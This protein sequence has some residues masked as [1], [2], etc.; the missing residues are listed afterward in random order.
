[1]S[2]TR[3]WGSQSLSPLPRPPQT[4]H[5]FSEGRSL[6]GLAVARGPPGL[7]CS[8]VIP[9]HAHLLGEVLQETLQSDPLRCAEHLQWRGRRTCRER[10]ALSCR[11][12]TPLARQRGARQ[13][14]RL[15]SREPAPHPWVPT[16]VGHRPFMFI[17]PRHICSLNKHG[18]RSYLENPAECCQEHTTSEKAVSL[19]RRRGQCTGSAVT[20]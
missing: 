7:R 17:V 9:V 18:P 14:P 6:E 10:D 15:P 1:M 8:L 13:A 2:P 11:A 4:E 5:R 3:H 20:Q 12:A 16:S 19:S